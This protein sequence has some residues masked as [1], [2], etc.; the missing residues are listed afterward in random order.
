MASDD[1]VQ[2]A[3]RALL[4]AEQAYRAEP[5]EANQRRVMRA[6]AEVRQAR[7]EPV[8]DQVP[9]PFLSSRPPGS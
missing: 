1:E 7:D 3:E 6:W 8:D 5:S 2:L 4:D 9:F